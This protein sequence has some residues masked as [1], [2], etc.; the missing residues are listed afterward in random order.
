MFVSSRKT[1]SSNSLKAALSRKGVQALSASMLAVKAMNTLSATPGFHSAFVKSDGSLWTMGNNEDGQLGINSQ[2]DANVSTEVS[3]GSLSMMVS[4]GNPMSG[5]DLFIN[6]AKHVTFLEAQETKLQSAQDFVARMQELKTLSQTASNADVSIYNVEF[7]SLQGQLY[8]VSQTSIG[9]EKLFA[10]FATDDYGNPNF[11]EAK[12]GDS[13]LDHTFHVQVKEAG[14][15]V[16]LGGS[17]SL[18]S[19]SL[20]MLDLFTI[21]RGCL[22]S[23][24]TIDAGT[25][26][27]SE[28]SN[29]GT[30]N[31]FSFGAPSPASTI[32][33]SDVSLSVLGQAA[34]NLAVLRSQ[35]GS[36]LT[37]LRGYHS[38]KVDYEVAKVAIGGGHSIFILKGDY[39]YTTGRGKSGQLANG[40]SSNQLNYSF[41]LSNVKHAAAGE[42][43]SLFLRNDGSLDGSGGNDFGQLGLSHDNNQSWPTQILP[44]GVRSIA[45]GSN[46]S[47]VVKE[48]GSL[49]GTGA[50]IHYQ[51]GLNDT[52]N[53]NQLTQIVSSGVR[54]AA[55]GN[56]FSLFLEDNGSMWGMGAS[57]YG[58]LGMGDLNS[59]NTPVQ[60]IASGVRQLSA[61]QSHSLFLKNDGSVWGMGANQGGQLGL[62]VLNQTNVPVKLFDHGAKE[63]H[64]GRHHSLILTMDGTLWGAGLNSK[65]ELGLGDLTGR[66][67]FTQITT[68]V[69]RLADVMS[70]EQTVSSAANLEMIWVEP[71]TFTMGSPTGE[72]GRSSNE[73]EHNV[74]LTKG[75][76]LG[77]YEVTQAQYEAVMTGN[78]NGLSATPSNWPNNPNRPV[79]KVSWDDAQ[80][81][82]ARLNSAEQTAG[83][84]PVG[85]S[86]VLPTESQ[87]EYACRA[88]TTTA[89]SWGATIVGSN[90]NWNYGAD[91]NQ[92]V[93][94]GQF[95]ANPWGFFDMHGNV[96]EWTADRYGTYP[97]GNPVIDPPGASSGS[98]R[99]LRGGSWH[100]DGAIL[101]SARRV[102]NAPGHRSYLTG[103]RVGFQEVNPPTDLNT[104]APLTIAEN[105][106]VGTVVGEFNA[107]DPDAGATL[108][109]HLVSGAGDGNNSLF[110]LETNGTLKT[111][112]VFDYETNAST[113]TI[114]VQAKDEHN[115]T[116]EGNFTVTLTMSVNE[117]VLQIFKKV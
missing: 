33:L 6:L 113:Y 44:S 46:H 115:A 97:I 52:S 104:T 40:G 2:N 31:V 107:T 109:Y 80:I 110:T 3:I 50:N 93:N 58:Q 72:T 88:G 51:L 19:V 34:S 69:M 78:G 85:W 106:P 77:K 84:L 17:I 66:N 108:S 102:G 48:D 82:L 68:G 59:Q 87:W 94:I 23:A 14:E 92:T 22:L 4:I 103:F 8:D 73:T 74:T 36:Q 99:V 105:Q 71:G 70:N 39:A 86:Y 91:P 32:L 89:Y 55:A 43:H 63:I 16:S 27:A 75:F 45:A 56:A 9:G 1:I 76:Y 57:P 96:Y 10:Q 64:A 41:A 95:S 5:P 111:A 20:G 116:V 90:A 100:N 42:N 15:D 112:T 30:G 12:F 25:L 101:R 117:L 83:R 53:R 98:D 62:G 35:N 7:G 54:S 61:G 81:F 114:R 67:T 26:A 37:G 49:W 60:I 28:Y 47:L 13:N 79:E 38:K 24:V 29:A 21:N 11:L 18:G 65:G